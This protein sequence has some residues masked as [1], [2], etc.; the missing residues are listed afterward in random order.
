VYSLLVVVSRYVNPHV[1]RPFKLPIAVPVVGFLVTAYMLWAAF[2]DPI[3]EGGPTG[4]SFFG[5]RAVWM[6]L[7]ALVVAAIGIALEKTS[8]VTSHLEQEVH[9]EQ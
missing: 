3:E 8:G 5:G 1:E 6:I 4:H 2:K 9:Q 7:A